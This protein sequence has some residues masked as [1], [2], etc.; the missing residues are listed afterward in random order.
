ML[1][2]EEEQKRTYKFIAELIS[3]TVNGAI[4]TPTNLLDDNILVDSMIRPS[5]GFIAGE[6]N[7]GVKGFLF[8]QYSVR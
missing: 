7:T 3:C 1:Q 6:F 2:K 5:V 8:G 4:R